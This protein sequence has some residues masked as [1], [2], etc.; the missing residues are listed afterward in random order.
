[1]TPILSET[2]DFARILRDAQRT[3][4]EPQQ[5]GAIAFLQATW[6]TDLERWQDDELCAVLKTNIPDP[7]RRLQPVDSPTNREAI[8]SWWMSDAEARARFSWELKSPACGSPVEDGDDQ[9]QNDF[10]S[11]CTFDAADEVIASVRTYP[12]TAASCPPIARWIAANERA[13]DAIREGFAAPQFFLPRIPRGRD[14]PTTVVALLSPAIEEIEM[15]RIATRSLTTRAMLHIGEGRLDQAGNDLAAILRHASRQGHANF[16]VDELV[17]IS[18]SLSALSATWT[19]LSS[20]ALPPALAQRVFT[21]L[22]ELP[23]RQSLVRSFDFAERLYILDML[24]HLCPGRRFPSE[25]DFSGP[26]PRRVPWSLDKRQLL[27]EANEL[28]DQIVAAGQESDWRT[29]SQRLLALEGDGVR[30]HGRWKRPSWPWMIGRSR[31]ARQRQA[32]LD[33][34]RPSL[35]CCFQAEDRHNT[36]LTL[37]QVAAG[38][39]AYGCGRDGYPDELSALVPSVFPQLPTDLYH[40]QP[41]QYRKTKN[42]FLL[43]SLGANGRDDRG[44]CGKPT[45][46]LNGRTLDEETPSSI[47]IELVHE[48]DRDVDTTSSADMQFLRTNCLSRLTS[49]IPDDADDIAVR[50]PMPPG[51]FLDPPGV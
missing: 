39:V 35:A 46:M 47:L 48:S 25:W 12:W 18:L 51:P 4:I 1:M 38:L 29:R 6:P 11:E 33:A 24:A 9:R 44:C 23:V 45:P 5:N 37:S 21:A 32:I 10:D 27:R 13:I 14:G 20:A 50:L 31:A 42:G 22:S 8:Q 7:E 28:I 2:S 30:Q 26:L 41:L 19:L 16:L 15:V 17:S 49:M 43:Y 36:L 40:S 3:D 34:V